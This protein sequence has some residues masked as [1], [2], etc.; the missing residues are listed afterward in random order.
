MVDSPVQSEKTPGE[1]KTPLIEVIKEKPDLRKKEPP[2]IK[3]QVSNPLTY[4]KSWWKRIIGNEGIEFRF[5]IRPLTAIALAIVIATFSFGVGRIMITSKKPFFKF[6]PIPSPTP[7]PT[8]DPWRE[9]AF[10]GI[11]RFS[12]VSNKY[13]LT[14]SS[15]EAINLETPSDVDLEKLIDRRIFATGKYNRITRT[16]VVADVSD[17]EVLPEEVEP[18]PLVSPSPAPSVLPLPSLLPIVEPEIEVILEE[19]PLLNPTATF[20]SEL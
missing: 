8:P 13:Y 1:S 7:S 10:S 4:L 20:S 9:T 6:V 5:K 16:L 3:L 14:T 18:V 12:G 2:L 11:L 19:I 15:S 17:L